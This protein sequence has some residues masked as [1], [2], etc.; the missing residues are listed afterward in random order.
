MTNAGWHVSREGRQYG[1]CAW[2]DLLNLARKGQLRPG[3]LL[4]TSGLEAWIRADQVP[5]LPWAAPVP[6]LPPTA[7]PPA[8]PP[9]TPDGPRRS[10]LSGL[11]GARSFLLI[12]S[13]GIV[14]LLVGA[15]GYLLWRLQPWR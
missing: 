10:A 2:E 3:D 15:G 1:P 7:E 11:L 12:A 6:P 9:A 4:W 14:L 13:L 8:A 5:G